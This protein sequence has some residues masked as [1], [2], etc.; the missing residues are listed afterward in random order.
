MSRPMK[1]DGCQVVDDHGG[2][3]LHLKPAD[4]PAHRG[5]AIA[6]DGLASRLTG[7]Y[8]GVD[9]IILKR[10][11]IYDKGLVEAYPLTGVD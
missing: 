5:G 7:D 2:E 1:C 8:C 6:G 3:W 9:C 10:K 11:A 4:S